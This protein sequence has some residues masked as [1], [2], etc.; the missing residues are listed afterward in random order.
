MTVLRNLEDFIC[1][2]AYLYSQP[3][4]APQ[5]IPSDFLFGISTYDKAQMASWIQRFQKSS[6]TPEPAIGKPGLGS[7][8]TTAP[9]PGNGNQDNPGSD[10]N[11]KQDQGQE[12]RM[13]VEEIIK[14]LVLKGYDVSDTKTLLQNGNREAIRKWMEGFKKNYPGV[15]E[16]IE[17]T[18]TSQPYKG[19]G[20]GM[21]P[22]PGNGNQSVSSPDPT[23][24]QNQG[25]EKRMPIEEVI[26]QLELK[27]YDVS[28][29]KTILQTGDREAIRT[30][31]NEF[32]KDNP[33]IVEN[34]EGTSMDKPKDQI[35]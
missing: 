21:N 18:G 16:A 4:D 6:I 27:G 13:P 33:G 26:K 11:L 5:N 24:G 35:K 31:I 2:G 34:I 7:V 8:N 19:I 15:V 30:W 23:Q 1:S 25:Q 9:G 10:P 12:R 29:A 22:P 20:N 28:E 3:I 32:K 14:Q 17:G